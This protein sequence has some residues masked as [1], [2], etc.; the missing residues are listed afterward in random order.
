M[1]IFYLPDLGEGLPEAEISEWYV[2]VGDTVEIDQYLV[3]VETAKALVE[4]PSPFAGVI[5]H[6]YGDSG[7][8]IKTGAPLVAFA[9]EENATTTS[10]ESKAA[11]VAGTLK[12]SEEVIEENALGI[13]SDKPTQYQRPPATPAVRAL[14]QQLQINL[15][16]LTGSGP[17]GAI[18]LDDVTHEA[19]RTTAAPSAPPRTSQNN[20]GK[21]QGVKRRMAEAMEASHAKVVPLTVTEEADI[22]RWPATEDT[23]V[24]LLTALVAALAVEP[25]LNAFFDGETLQH[26]L[27]SSINVG[28]A[29]DTPHGLFA[30]VI[31]DV[32]QQSNTALRQIIERYKKEV[33]ERTIVHQD[34][35]G[36][37]ILLSNFGS[38]YGKFG[39]PTVI[40][41][42]V[43]I[44][45]IGRQRKSVVAYHDE[46][47][48][49]PLLPI[50]ITVDHRVIT[51]GE[52]CRF[53]KAFI[54]N[55]E[56]P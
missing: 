43:A 22:H 1:K 3:S 32:A 10:D 56:K 7:D 33:L 28:L 18:T 53:L 38:I 42:M 37:T 17:K 4:I 41:P 48:I 14:A 23:T 25:G 27:Q 12:T 30:P 46:M 47:V 35:A 6:C 45:G 52:L 39:N 31:R 34:L 51:G 29:M 19:N 50:S 15:N 13:N 49:H 11:T 9:I 40:P 16:N 20:P 54:A 21:I 24:R 44:V 26:N 36:A 55:L 8:M 2:N 5:H